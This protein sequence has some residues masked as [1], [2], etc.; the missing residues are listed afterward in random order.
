MKPFEELLIYNLVS[1]LIITVGLI[2][3]KKVIRKESTKNNVLKSISILVVMIHISS[4]Y[5][6]FFVGGGVANVE[7]NILL[8]IYPCNVVMWLLVLTS[9]IKNKKGKIFSHFAEFTF[10]VGTLCG[11]VGVV[12]NFNFLNTPSFADYD[13]LKGL[14]SH[15]VMIFGTLYI[16]VMGYVKINVGN[17][18]KSILY[19]MILFVLIGLSVNTLFDIFGIESVNSMYLESPPFPNIP[20]INFYTIGLLG[21][22]ISFI[23]LN[24]YELFKYIKE[25]RWIYKI[26]KKVEDYNV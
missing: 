26:R 2:L 14:I 24:L 10:I 23:G 12:F 3:C 20:F 5:V 9:F 18:M 6:D 4:L 21:L 16:G 25:D 17:T 13:I 15:S 11:V 19:G 1:L 8:P 7:D 22:L